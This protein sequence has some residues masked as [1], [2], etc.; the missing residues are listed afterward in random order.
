MEV[1]V[2]T[3]K[4]E[5]LPPLVVFTLRPIHLSVSFTLTACS[6]FPSLPLRLL[7]SAFPFLGRESQA[8]LEE[9][10]PDSVRAARATK[11]ELPASFGC[12]QRV[13]MG[14]R[15]RAGASLEAGS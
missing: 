10:L 5:S 9:K 2:A 7:R 12:Q 1:S 11:S 8:S 3:D 13:G 14:G 4:G 15:G 6:P